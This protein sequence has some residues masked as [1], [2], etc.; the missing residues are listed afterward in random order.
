MAIDILSSDNNTARDRQFTPADPVGD[1]ARM[2]VD[3]D[4]HGRLTSAERDSLRKHAAISV[5]SLPIMIRGVAVALMDAINEG[6]FERSHIGNAVWS[7]DMMADAMQ[8]MQILL[9][10]LR[11]PA[12][13]PN[14]A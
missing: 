9:A 10:D 2:L 5:D 12:A 3:M 13:M 6:N 7:I 1:I 11:T 14:H 8:G 4:R